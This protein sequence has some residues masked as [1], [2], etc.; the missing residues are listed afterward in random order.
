MRPTINC[1]ILIALTSADP[2]ILSLKLGK[3]LRIRHD[4]VFYNKKMLFY[5]I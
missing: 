2:E 1:Q 4:K 5:A 3:T